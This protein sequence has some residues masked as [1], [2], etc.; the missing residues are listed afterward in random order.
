MFTF[1]LA[2]PYMSMTYLMYSY[3]VTTGI[4]LKMPSINL[5]PFGKLIK[6]ESGIINKNTTNE[7]NICSSDFSDFF[8]SKV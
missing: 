1:L 3:G 4:S 8:V 6:K 2:Y 5:E 7:S